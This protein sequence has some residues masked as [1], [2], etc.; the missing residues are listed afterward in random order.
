MGRTQTTRLLWDIWRGRGKFH[1]I[2]AFMR[3]M[4]EGVTQARKCLAATQDRMKAAADRH[5]RLE[6]FA[7]RDYVLLTHHYP[8]MRSA[9]N[10]FSKI[11]Q[12][13]LALPKPLG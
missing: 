10:R 7:V 12:R 3:E 9:T 13:W 5:R 2:L 6:T 11:Q 8:A 1:K 4:Q